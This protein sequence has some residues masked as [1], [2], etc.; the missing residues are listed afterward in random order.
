MK[1]TTLRLPQN[2]LTALD[3]E[4]EEYGFDNRTEYIRHI[5]DNRSVVIENTVPYSKENT[6][7]LGERVDELEKRVEELENDR[8]RPQTEDTGSRARSHTDA[9]HGSDAEDR[10]VEQDSTEADSES[11]VDEQIQQLNL[12]GGA[13]SREGREALRAMYD[14][15]RDQGR[16][17]RSDFLSDI[18]PDHRVSYGSDETWW[19]AVALETEG[20][21]GFVTLAKQR[22]DLRP[23]EGRGQQ[24]FEYLDE[25][26]DQ[27]IYAPTGEFGQS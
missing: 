12:P 7:N 22:D 13:D 8:G 1:P 15:V 4:W 23:P 17:R 19:K 21:E 6:E 11:S 16:A 26:D 24:W 9:P 14:Y 10:R 20:G 3:Q 5:L 18:F 25:D 27:G 2:T